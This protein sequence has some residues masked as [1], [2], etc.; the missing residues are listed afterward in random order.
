[1][2]AVRV[3]QNREVTSCK[4]KKKPKKQIELKDA[5]TQSRVGDPAGLSPQVT[6][7]T[8]TYSFDPLLI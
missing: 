8:Y 6:P 5:K 1:M 7:F 2:R 4:K 3:N